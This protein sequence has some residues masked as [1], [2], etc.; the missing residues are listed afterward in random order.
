M[1][2]LESS[3]ARGI[4]FRFDRLDQLSEGMSFDLGKNQ[5][6]FGVTG[7]IG[8][9]MGQVAGAATTSGYPGLMIFIVAVILAAM[10]FLL[11]QQ[12]FVTNINKNN[13]DEKPA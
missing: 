2:L 13:K 7:E 8:K 5:M 6:A 10:Y 9:S 11:I 1:Q 3:L 4:N 12:L